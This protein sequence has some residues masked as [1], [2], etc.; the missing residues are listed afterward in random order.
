MGVGRKLS[1]VAHAYEY[2]VLQVFLETE[3]LTRCIFL[4]VHVTVM[5][6]FCNYKPECTG[7]FVHSAV[8]IEASRRFLSFH[9]NAVTRQQMSDSVNPRHDFWWP[10]L[11]PAARDFVASPLIIQRILSKQHECKRMHRLSY[12]RVVASITTGGRDVSVQ[13]R[14]VWVGGTA[15]W[16][17]KH[18]V[19]CPLHFLQRNSRETSGLELYGLSFYILIFRHSLAWCGFIVF[20]AVSCRL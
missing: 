15:R 19:T 1:V 7:K 2:W 6:W 9:A 8:I 11:T 10:F 20:F 12:S 14:L 3:P 18:R 4:V 13:W 5:P 16:Q 17:I